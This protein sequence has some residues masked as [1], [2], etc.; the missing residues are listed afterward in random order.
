MSFESATSSV[1][2]PSSFQ[3]TQFAVV[4]PKRA[5]YPSRQHAAP[6]VS[7]A[8][9]PLLQPPLLLRSQMMLRL[10]LLPNHVEKTKINDTFFV[11]AFTIRRN[12]VLKV[13]R[14]YFK[15]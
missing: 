4:L 5:I 11:L 6:E 10:L 1:R 14:L 8:L 15:L 3:V 12:R 13:M 2:W 9:R 7:E